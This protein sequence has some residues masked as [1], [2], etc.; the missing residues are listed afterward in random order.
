MIA[1]IQDAINQLIPK[2]HKRSS[3]GWISF[4]APCC[5]HRGHKPDTRGRGG[6]VSNADGSISYHCFNC[7]FKT[8]Y[9]SGQYLGYKFRRWL[10]WLGAD[11][12]TIQ[13]LVIESVRIREYI[14]QTEHE[15]STAEIEFKSRALPE[16][17]Y[18]VDTDPP[19]L[20]YCLDRAIDLNKYPMLVSNR[21]EYNLNRRVIVP[22]TWNNKL[23]GYTAR[24]WDPL[25]KP[26]YH[27]QYDPNFVFNY[28]RQ[29]LNA[30]F[31]LVCEGPFD[32]ISIDGIAVLSNF[33]SDTQADIIDQLGREVIL[34]P[35][36]DKAGSQLI[37][38][39]LEFGW[40]VSYPVWHE[41][42]KDANE[43]VVKYGKLFTIKSIL[44]SK[45]TN[46]LK[47][48]LMRKKLYN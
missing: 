36:R 30:K 11:E 29:P 15:H 32:A 4:D 23:I 40:S 47:I 37:D 14:G 38:R 21:T 48:E 33:C 16:P 35:D 7:Q 41:T 8:G 10:S 42:C 22:F 43:A 6:I 24:A 44:E 26:K 13:R 2:K 34:V 31:V 12:N 39:A 27:S 1:A 17:V 18:L 20:K 3:S 19:A 9:R 45:Q 25:V 46:K 28:D 5:H